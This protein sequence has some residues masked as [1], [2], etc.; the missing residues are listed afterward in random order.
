MD[1]ENV[2]NIEILLMDFI[3]EARESDSVREIL[4]LSEDIVLDIQTILMKE[5]E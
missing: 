2:L 5:T 3:K 1:K 4:S